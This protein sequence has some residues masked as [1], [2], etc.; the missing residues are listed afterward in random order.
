MIVFLTEKI[1]MILKHTL[2]KSFN[3]KKKRKGII[4]TKCFNDID[5]NLIKKFDFEVNIH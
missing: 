5:Q 1:F 3:K 4:N 2:S